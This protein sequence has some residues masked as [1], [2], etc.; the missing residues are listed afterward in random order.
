M[1]ITTG[2]KQHLSIVL[3]HNKSAT[4]YAI[5]KITP[6]KGAHLFKGDL[7]VCVLA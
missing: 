4:I 2:I 7:C 5:I 6:F 1:G 3:P